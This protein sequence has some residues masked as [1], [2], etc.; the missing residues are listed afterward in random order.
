MNFNC[1]VLLLALVATPTIAMIRKHDGEHVGRR[2]LGHYKRELTGKG[3]G[4]K[5]GGGKKGGEMVEEC[6]DFEEIYDGGELP[7]VCDFDIKITFICNNVGFSEGFD[8]ITEIYYSYSSGRTIIAENLETGKT[9]STPP[10]PYGLSETFDE[11]TNSSNFIQIGIDIWILYEG[12]T[13][14][15]FMP[16][17]PGVLFA[18][19]YYDV[20]QG[21]DPFPW[22]F[23]AA[24]G[25]I[26]YD[27]CAELTPSYY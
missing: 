24:S 7:Q 18:E 13:G 21:P 5:K 23:N 10:G 6:E 22:T 1:A 15:N 25:Q 8:N 9:F 3:K 16:D 12:D 27:Y 19:G 4:G 26:L 20:T 2:S 14:L 11:M 17:G